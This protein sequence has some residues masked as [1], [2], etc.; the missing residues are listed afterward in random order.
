M[1]IFRYIAFK[2]NSSLVFMGQ[3]VNMAVVHLAKK[4][5]VHIIQT[6]I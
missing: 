5:V 1:D 4:T 3:E 6:T 2:L